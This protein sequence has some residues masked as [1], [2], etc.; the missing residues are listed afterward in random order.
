MHH[1]LPTALI[2]QALERG[3]R[4]GFDIMEVAGLP[5]GTVYPALRRLEKE[6]LVSARWEDEEAARAGNRPARR[7]YE[8][9]QFGEEFL[10]E[11]RQKFRML[12]RAIPARP[13]ARTSRA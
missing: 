4:H 9:N 6:G 12:S 10:A 1:T 5:S 3:Y 11:A 8:L 13:K 7:Y 2:L